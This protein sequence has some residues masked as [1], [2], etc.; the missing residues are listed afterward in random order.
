MSDITSYYTTLQGAWQ[1]DCDIENAA[2][3]GSYGYV[4]KNTC[5]PNFLEKLQDSKASHCYSGS[6]A[7]PN[8]EYSS[9]E[10]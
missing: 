7:T 2:N 8:V 3:S 5:S 4:G 6:I 9:A 1:E 10:G